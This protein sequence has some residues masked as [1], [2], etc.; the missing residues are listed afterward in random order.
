[1]RSIAEYP[2]KANVVFAGTERFLFVTTDSGAHWSR[3]AANLPATRF[4][5][6]I[7]HPRTKDLVLGTHGRSIWILDDASP[8]AEWS[9]TIAAKSSYL[10]APRRATLMQYWEDIS[11]TAQSMFTAE[12]PADGAE[13]TYYLGRAGAVGQAHRA[14]S[15]RK[16]DSRDHRADVARRSAPRY[17]GPSARSASGNRWRRWIRWRRG[18]RRR[19]WWRRRRA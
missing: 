19:R 2:G 7:V 6:I 1:V 11:N 9:P 18:R 17:V 13:F 12:N 10:F 5:D 16:S 3:I 8:I 4:D 14:W 15:G